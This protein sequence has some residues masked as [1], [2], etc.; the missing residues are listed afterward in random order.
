MAAKL[1][2]LVR[3]AR[4]NI[5]ELT[6]DTVIE[7]AVGLEEKD[8]YTIIFGLGEYRGPL[9]MKP[10][11]GKAN[12]LKLGPDAQKKLLL[13]A[14]ARVNLQV[15][16]S[17]DIKVGPL[18]GVLISRSKKEKLLAGGFDSVYWRFQGW[19]AQLKGL[20]IFFSLEDIDATAQK[21]KGYFFSREK[22]WHSG[23]FPLPGVIYDRCFG[24][25]GRQEAYGLR[26]LLE[27][28]RLQVRVFN[29]AVKIGKEE[30]YAHLSRYP[31]LQ[32]QIPAFRPF[33][34]EA[35]CELL[36]E[37]LSLYLKP[38]KLYKGQ[39]ILRVAR[40][41]E[42]YRLN[43]RDE[44]AKKNRSSYFQKAAD[45]LEYLKNHIDLTQGYILQS[46]I[47]LAAYMGNRF[48]VRVMLQKRNPRIW[49]V[50]ALNARIA[51]RG[52]IITS[53]RS[54]GKVTT[55]PEVLREVF[56]GREKEI[57]REV[58]DFSREIGRKLEEKFGLLGELGVDLGLDTEG[59]VWLIEV[60]GKPLKVSFIQMKDRALAQ[61]INRTPIQLGFHLDG[62][63]APDEGAVS[64]DREGTIYTLKPM[65]RSL[66]STLHL[67]K[68]QL[69]H[70]GVKAGDRLRLR[71]GWQ[72]EPVQV[73]M[74]KGDAS[75]VNL[76]LSYSVLQG[77]NLPPGMPLTLMN[78][79][80][81]VMAF[82]PTVGMTISYDSWEDLAHNSYELK[83]TARLSLEKG[84]LFY[85]FVPNM[86]LWDRGMVESYYLHP[87]KKS[88][89]KRFLPLPQVLYD[90]ATY[91]FDPDRRLE[92]KEAN[93][94]M[95]ENKDMQVIN[96]RRYFGKRE[97][98]E[99]L[100]F[101]SE[102]E[103]MVPSWA[104]LSPVN[105]HAFCKN[106]EAV[107]AKSNYGSFGWGVM[108]VEQR[109]QHV[110]V[111]AGG[112]EIREWCF[113]N[114]LQAYGFLLE[115]LGA[116]AVLQEGV[117]LACLEG[118]PFDMRVLAHKD[119]RARWVIS[120]VSFRIASPQAVVTNVSSGAR[121]LIV[122]PGE[123][124]PHPLL[125]WEALNSFCAKALMALEASLG[126]LGE[127][128]LDVGMDLK[129]KLWLFEANSKPNTVDYKDL[130]TEEACRLVY[131][132]P[133]EY[134]R[135]LAAKM[136]DVYNL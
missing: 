97:T 65:S 37:H 10:R 12:I 115:E 2:A 29:Q 3:Y 110:L 136:L 124:L 120:T 117:T 59:K 100:S 85:C 121:E 14:G 61:R 1:S 64:S 44:T 33:S 113:P 112:S 63:P 13:P 49:E 80:G 88:W 30:T 105:L 15:Y 83:K 25:E 81:R 133:L 40:H 89:E 78:Y 67:N 7:T 18:L 123:R 19:A 107:Y 28:K 130:T 62:F 106:Y 93:A 82:G 16:N 9:K 21:V 128:G 111:K 47:N 87:I 119:G 53:P 91:P 134:A 104:P 114:L 79:R 11:W 132:L 95:R 92:A 135:Y 72:I 4:S 24:R 116:E 54:G 68:D 73:K 60:N 5:L 51:P 75:P 35:F 101:F 126:C 39:G 122:G 43:W 99:A 52:S 129:G 69:A 103:K 77:L 131:G 56:P 74:Q 84:V 46:S 45:V 23:P 66:D 8:E 26:E 38:D 96:A 32:K 42:G 109:G 127:V 27:E 98:C 94:R 55:L 58:E 36:Q 71:V 90:Q 118:C 6:E 70:F 125:S 31:Q 76:Y 86:V 17:G 34:R 102:T 20:I 41:G 22:I 57:I 48:D 50:T 108:R